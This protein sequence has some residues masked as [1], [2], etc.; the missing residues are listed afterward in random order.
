[1]NQSGSLSLMCPSLKLQSMR[2][3]TNHNPVPALPYA[4]SWFTQI[5][6]G[7]HIRQW[8]S[9]SRKGFIINS[10]SNYLSKAKLHLPSWSSAAADFL[11]TAW[12]DARSQTTHTHMNELM[13]TQTLWLACMYA[14]IH[15]QFTVLHIHIHTHYYR[16]E[17]HLRQS[18]GGAGNERGGRGTEVWSVWSKESW[19]SLLR[20][21]SPHGERDRVTNSEALKEMSNQ[22]CLKQ[23]T[24]AQLWA[25][26]S[27]CA[28]VYVWERDS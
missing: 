13:C 27:A 15:T 6:L 20:L 25:Q 4:Q 14:Q 23:G 24:Y 8:Y 26:M 12:K 19:F 7:T 28:C 2:L 21:Q 17:K 18:G 16:V 11:L 1:M 3:N 9:Y 22:W 10:I 5:H